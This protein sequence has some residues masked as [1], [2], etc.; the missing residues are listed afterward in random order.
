MFTEFGMLDKKTPLGF[1]IK[2]STSYKEVFTTFKR[3]DMLL[4]TP[5]L[6]KLLIIK[7]NLF[8]ILNELIII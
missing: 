2:Q 8:F 5:P 7:R 1:K 6:S 4:E 3:E